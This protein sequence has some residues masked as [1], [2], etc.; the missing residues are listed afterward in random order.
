MCVV[1][2]S[3]SKAGTTLARGNQAYPSKPPSA[4]I[5]IGPVIKKVGTAQ[6]ILDRA[7]RILQLC[8]IL[9]DKCLPSCAACQLAED[10]V[11][12]F[13]NPMAVARDGIKCDSG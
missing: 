7:Q 4:G 3:R 8:A 11:S 12:A 10:A 6:L 1:P 9:H 5:V 13:V 2:L